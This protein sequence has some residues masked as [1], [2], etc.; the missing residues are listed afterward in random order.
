MSAIPGRWMYCSV[1]I[2]LDHQWNRATGWG[3]AL[4]GAIAKRVL[5]VLKLCQGFGIG[6][7]DKI[8][9]ET[10]IPS[11]AKKLRVKTGQSSTVR[12]ASRCSSCGK[13]GGASA[14]GPDAGAC[15]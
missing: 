9:K 2:L 15:A 3:C 5:L 13:W 4:P 14:V 8:E 12:M 11:H 7:V 10:K 6:P 1:Q